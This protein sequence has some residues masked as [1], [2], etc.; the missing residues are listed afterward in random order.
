MSDEMSFEDAV[1]ALGDAVELDAGVD[2]GDSGSPAPAPAP[3][4]VSTEQA[5]P[6][7]HSDTPQGPTPGATADEPVVE[8]ELVED[9]F[10]TIDPS[11]LP[12]ELQ[13][14]YK[15]LQADYTRKTQEAAAWRKLGEE[16]GMDADSLREASELY[17]KL[18]DPTNWPALHA[19][20]S[21]ALQQQGYTPAEAHAEASRQI[22]E[23]AAPASTGPSPLD[24]LMDDP[25]LAPVAEHLRQTRDELDALRAELHE[26]D[27]RAAQQAEYMSMVSD[28][29]RQESAI[30]ELKKPDGSPLYAQEDVDFM[31]ELSSFHGGNLL[32]AQQRFEEMKGRW[33]V[34]YLSQKESVAATVPAP[35]GGGN[36]MTVPADEPAVDLDE[37]ERRALEELRQQDALDFAF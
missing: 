5:E 18:A 14:I 35:V 27:V 9:S 11:Q 7:V 12:L 13:P 24:G 29:Q 34:G 36:A 25:E 15:S 3:T 32:A 1:Q 10:T 4:P 30:R 26:R 19:E 16:T 8:T 28:L 33:A 6:V 23:V 17:T 37:A 22:E 2:G 21:T 20:L 31:Y